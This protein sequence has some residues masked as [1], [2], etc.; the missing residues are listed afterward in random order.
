[1]TNNCRIDGANVG[2]VQGPII[3]YVGDITLVYH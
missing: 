1:M 3:G 2:R